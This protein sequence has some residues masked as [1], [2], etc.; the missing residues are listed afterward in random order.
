MSADLIDMASDVSIAGLRVRERGL[1]LVR[2]SSACFATATLRSASARIFVICAF[3]A[4]SSAMPLR[5][6]I[7]WRRLPR[8]SYAIP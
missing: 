4:G 3:C 7:D 1:E 6:V 8:R 2:R 5:S